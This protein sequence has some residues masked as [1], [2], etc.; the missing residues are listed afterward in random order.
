MTEIYPTR[1]TE[2]DDSYSEADFTDSKVRLTLH[3]C[4]NLLENQLWTNDKGGWFGNTEPLSFHNI[5]A[6]FRNLQYAANSC[7]FWSR[8]GKDFDDGVIE[9]E[10]IR[11]RVALSSQRAQIRHQTAMDLAN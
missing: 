10:L 6:Q 5:Q 2:F 11:F 8:S 9:V 7:Q 4:P 3:M 1:N